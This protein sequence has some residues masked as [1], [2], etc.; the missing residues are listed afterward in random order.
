MR[1]L[2]C[3]DFSSQP[4][5]VCALDVME[6]FADILEHFTLRDVQRLARTSSA[7]FLFRWHGL[8]H[9]GLVTEIGH[10]RGR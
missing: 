10:L 8:R 4:A 5:Q 6:L 1:V 9:S 7:V 3:C 2:K